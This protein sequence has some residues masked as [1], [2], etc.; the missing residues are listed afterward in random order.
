MTPSSFCTDGLFERERLMGDWGGS[1]AA[2]A[3]KGFEIGLNYT[4]E[5]LAN[6]TGGVKQGSTYNGLA[7]VSLDIDLEK[8]FTGWKGGSLYV[9]GLSAHGD[10]AAQFVG[11][12]QGLSN[13]EAHSSERLYS[14]HFRQA[15]LDDKLAFKIGN[16]LA[17]DDFSTMDLGAVFYN[18]S[19]GWPAFI[20][21]NTVN[22]GPAYF[23]AAP[24]IHAIAELTESI[25][26]QA[27]VYDGDSFDDPIG[28]TTI[29]EHG[30]HLELSKEQGMFSMFEIGYR[31]SLGKQ[32]GV[33]KLGG[34]HHSADFSNTIT[35][36]IIGGNHGF[37]FS[38][39]QSV[40]REDVDGDQGL[41]VFFRAG[42]S[43]GDRSLADFTFDTGLHYLGLVPGR[44]ED[45]LGLGVSYLSVSDDVATAERLVG[46]TVLSDYE[47]A[48]ETVYD[49]AVTPALNLQPNLQWIRHPGGSD[50]LTDA[51]VF[52]MRANI[53]F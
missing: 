13:I 41:G 20:S 37:Y 43:P 11:D 30:T 17:D 12:I 42:F 22:T 4:A 5:Y 35:G 21:L 38:A 26:L 2:L 40:Y 47:L 39:E 23:V 24:G 28:G 1:R 48:M 44:D 8:Q 27:G 3:E 45:T 29:S 18:S 36:A 7:H 50:A 6:L 15:F 52:G 25:F 53:R 33:F 9:S 51:W 49:F 10:G 14:F 46:S 32:P 19:F 34:W 16:L 31:T